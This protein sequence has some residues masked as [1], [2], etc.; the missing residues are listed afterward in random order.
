MAL[1]GC[2]VLICAVKKLL[3]IIQSSFIVHEQYNK[4]LSIQELEQEGNTYCP[5]VPVHVDVLKLT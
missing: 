3:P 1:I 2:N 4:D 5:L